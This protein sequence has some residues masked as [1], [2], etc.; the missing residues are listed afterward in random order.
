MQSKQEGVQEVLNLFNSKNFELAETKIKNLIDKYKND[1]I[2]YSICGIILSHQKK[3]NETISFF[4]KAIKINS[5]NFEIYNNFGVALKNLGDIENAID[6]YKKTLDLKPDFV[7]AIFNLALA[8]TKTENY[9]NAIKKS[10]EV[11]NL[12]PSN[13][14]AYNNLGNIYRYLNK[15]NDAIL[16]YR[17]ALETNPN[18]M[19][20]HMHLSFIT[21]YN[22]ENHKHIKEMEE[23]ILDININDENKMFLSFGLGKAFNDTKNYEKSFKYIQEANNLRKKELGYN[24]E[25]NINLFKNLKNFFQEPLFNKFKNC[26]SLNSTPIF[27]V[28]MPRSGTTLVEQILSSH[29]KVHGGGELVILENIISKYFSLNNFVNL[30]PLKIKNIANEYV[31]TIR[32]LSQK[33]TFI[34]NKL[35]LNFLWIG[36]IKICLPNSKIIHCIRNNKDTCLSIFKTHFGSASNRYAYNLVD[37]GNYYN[38][39][40]DL[41]KHWNKIL[42][43]F[44]Y[45]MSYEKLI[46]NQKKQTKELLDA[47][48]LEWSNKCIEFNKN[49]R[50][51]KTASSLQVR[52]SLY[53]DSVNSW[54]NYK[55]HLKPLIEILN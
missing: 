51:V 47:C 55:K 3:F 6:N 28:G 53:K 13:A 52:K 22:S 29:P 26:G 38:L 18:I 7:P 21:E 42:P 33:S 11:I 40:E 54:K 27:I 9:E 19:E 24:V 10:K 2:L 12:N 15:K 50:P 43:N 31:K 41:M 45:E 25:K 36:L 49:I 20:V 16:N 35:P 44:I 5:N 1:E 14:R 30:N 4:K 32:K 48:N 34:T 17:K 39:Y 8:Y 37:L 23:A 46:S